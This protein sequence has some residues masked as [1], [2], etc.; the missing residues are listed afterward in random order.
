MLNKGPLGATKKKVQ[1]FDDDH[2]EMDSW[3]LDLT[4]CSDICSSVTYTLDL[5]PKS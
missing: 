1:Q 4:E 3:D 5:R 2:N